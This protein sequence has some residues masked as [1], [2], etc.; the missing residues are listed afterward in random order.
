MEQL[1]ERAAQA[2][3]ENIRDGM[4]VGLGSG[5][6][7]E[8]GIHALG[9]R[10]AAGLRITAVPTSDASATLAAGYGIR[11]VTM[12]EAPIIDLTFD[13]AD[14]VDPQLNLI[15]GLG[16]ALLREKVVASATERQIIVIDPGK[17]VDRLGGPVPVPVEVIPFGWS[18]VQRVLQQRGIRAELRQLQTG[19][20]LTDN[21]NY[22]VDCF[23]PQGILDPAR[24]DTVLNSIPGV[25]ENGLFVGLVS[26]VIVGQEQG[27]CRIIRRS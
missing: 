3:V 17:L 18:L 12:Q 24:T 13:G 19:P 4:V 15:K 16:G 10:V 9:R 20:Y 2:A 7:A 1:K 5:S 21:G 6:T 11:L 22:I 8:Y 23:F 25:V 27:E 26:E 14:Q